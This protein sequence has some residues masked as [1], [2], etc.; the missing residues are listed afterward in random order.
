MVGGPVDFLPATQDNPE[1]YQ[2]FFA[3]RGQYKLYQLLGIR[4]LSQFGGYLK[5]LGNDGIPP[6]D[7]DKMV[8]AGL[9]WKHK[10]LTFEQAQD[11][12]EQF[13]LLGK[14]FNDLNDL[15][16]KSLAFCGLI[17]IKIYDISKK[18][19]SMSSEEIEQ[20]IIEELA[21]QKATLEEKPGDDM[22][23]PLKTGQT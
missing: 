3:N 16:L 19:Q 12:V 22:G 9:I 11:I 1:G 23:E 2:L 4:T 7:L 5:G 10:S 18:M 15:I 14:T 21:K 20:K 17:D 13:Y 6:E 8:L